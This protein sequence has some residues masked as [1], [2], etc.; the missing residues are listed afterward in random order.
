MKILITGAGGFIGQYLSR[1]LSAD[2]EIHALTRQQLDLVDHVKLGQCLDAKFDAVIHCAS[3]GR[4]SARSRDTKIFYNNLTSW[5]NLVS[6]K[7]RYGLLINL[8]TGAEFDLDSNIDQAKESYIWTGHTDY[9]Y[10]QSKNLIARMCQLIPNF[11]NL[12][13]FGCFDSTESETRPIKKCKQLISQ[14]LPFAIAGD[15]YFDMVSLS[16]LAMVVSA[17][18]DGQIHD[19]DL[20]VVYNEKHKL[21]EILKIYS[22]LHSL[23][24]Y[25]VQIDSTDS[26]NYTGDSKILD[27][28][29]LPLLGLEQSLANYL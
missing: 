29:Q 1:Y 26:K 15:R 22:R 20:N 13:L 25:L 12:R 21:S 17:V 3:E 2:H 27:S 8:A 14:S 4:N 6:Y 28:Y 5:Q 19:K 10:G 7:D 24:P 16:D 11:Y 9:S 18:L 23:D